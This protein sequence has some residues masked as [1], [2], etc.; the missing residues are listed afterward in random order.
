MPSKN[1]FNQC[2]QCS[3]LLP[4]NKLFQLRPLALLPLR[5][6]HPAR[7]PRAYLL[8]ASCPLH[9]KPHLHRTQRHPTLLLSH[10]TQRVNMTLSSSMEVSKLIM[11]RVAQSWLPSRIRL[12]Y[13]LSQLPAWRSKGCIGS[14]TLVCYII[15]VRHYKRRIK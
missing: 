13:W 4:M 2:T 11:R 1:P 14:H 7:S 6:S 8:C 15:P 12:V 3:S 10:L 9:P 5:S